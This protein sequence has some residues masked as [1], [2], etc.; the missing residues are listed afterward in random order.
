MRK[1]AASP[2][3]AERLA[4]MAKMAEEYD[5]ASFRDRARQEYQERQAEGRLGPAQRTCATLDEKAG[6]KVGTTRSPF[7]VGEGLI[8]LHI[9]LQ[10]N[11]LWLNPEDPDTFPEDLVDLLEDDVLSQHLDKLRYQGTVEGRLR[12]RTQ[13]DALQP[14]KPGSELEIDTEESGPSK[15]G[16][17]DVPYTEDDIEECTAFLKLSVSPV[18]ICI[19]IAFI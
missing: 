16:V 9:L 8:T 2:S 15:A 1:R 3:A 12:A 6:R 17:R 19:Q 5:H 10:F 11:V 13:A 7:T 14:I 18:Y 4:K